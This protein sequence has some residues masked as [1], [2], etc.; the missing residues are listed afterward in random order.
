MNLGIIIIFEKNDINTADALIF[1][2]FFNQKVKIC[3]VNN[4]NNEKFFKLLD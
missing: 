3:L 2:S 1:K 4:G